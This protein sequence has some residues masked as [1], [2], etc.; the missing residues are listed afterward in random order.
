VYAGVPQPDR[1]IKPLTKGEIKMQS[2]GAKMY[3]RH[4]SIRLQIHHQ[5][6]IIHRADGAKSIVALTAR[7]HF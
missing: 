6:Y 7:K 1:T 5:T 4:I 2:E 3:P